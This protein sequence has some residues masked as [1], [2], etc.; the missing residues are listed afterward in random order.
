MTGC[1][2]MD[3]RVIPRLD[4]FG[5]EYLHIYVLYQGD[6]KVLD[7][8]WL[9]GLYRR[10]RPELVA[11]GITSVPTESYVDRIEVGHGS[12]LATARPF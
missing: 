9:N 7:P 6:G 8:V 4:E 11:L 3:I 10:M 12:E 1:H 5:D 2:S